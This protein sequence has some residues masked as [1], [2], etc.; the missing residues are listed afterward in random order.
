MNAILKATKKAAAVVL[1]LACLA[2][3]AQA[4]TLNDIRQRK[5]VLVAIDLGTP[6]FGM[7]DSTPEIYGTRNTGKRRRGNRSP[8][9]VDSPH[10]AAG[11]RR[12]AHRFSR[13]VSANN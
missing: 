4:D 1:G 9:A 12:N 13:S 6:P 7:T 2:Q 10:D 8:T 5:K 11:R 3:V